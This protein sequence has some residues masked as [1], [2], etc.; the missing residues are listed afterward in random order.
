VL[1]NPPG[2]GV[3]V[4]IVCRYR[5][6]RREEFR[7]GCGERVAVELQKNFHEDGAY[8]LVAVY[9]RMISDDP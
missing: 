6:D 7:I 3:V 2:E 9:E 1:A 8:P 4:S 5:N